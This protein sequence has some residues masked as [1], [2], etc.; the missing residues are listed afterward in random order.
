M[1]PNTAVY[2][3][4]NATTSMAP[5]VLD[6]MIPYLKDQFY[7]PSSSY[8]PARG[9][10]DAIERARESVARLLG[11]GA[12]SEILFTSGATEANNAALWGAL[13]A[14]PD[15]RH[16]VTT[17]VE[18]PA[19]LE[20]AKEME[21]LGYRVTFLPVDAAGRLDAKDVLRALAPDTAV[22]SIMHANNETGVVFP[23]GELA[24]LI[25]RA[26]PKVLVHTDA[27]Q[28]VGKV[29]LSLAKEL[30]AVDLLSLSAHKLHGP[31]GVGALYVRR[32]ARWRPYLIGGHQERGRRAG[33][34]NV[35]GVVGLGRACELALEHWRDEERLRQ[36]Q[37][38]LEKSVTAAIP[39]TLVNGQK[40]DRLPNT[41][42]FAFEFVE[43][44]GILMAL[45][46]EGILAS[47]GSACTSGSLD[48]S[49][50]LKAMNVPFTA[51]HGSLRISTSRYTTGEE[52]DHL[53]RVLPGVI[54][55]L[56]RI[57]P[58]W[59][60]AKNAP[61]EDVDIFVQEKFR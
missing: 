11:A 23:V 29:P 27:T 25:K 51:A 52:V 42:N 41:S 24:R 58:Y 8:G 40:A 20:V 61:R 46:D 47:S 4:N 44:E 37:E 16:V 31:K 35:A 60:A 30:S 36:L 55:S 39:H 43:G 21:R 26:D 28:T 22:V 33:T 53:I 32:G 57:S 18:H 54:E 13:R 38:W 5:E 56:R 34:E 9:P 10:R 2:L 14:N 50:V 12:R 19:V 45:Q 7:N 59:D 49:H 1:E 3:D 15:R 48:P 6:A 17:Q